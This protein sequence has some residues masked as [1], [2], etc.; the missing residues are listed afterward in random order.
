MSRRTMLGCIVAAVALMALATAGTA[1]V[2]HDQWYVLTLVKGEVT[3]SV[4]V[5]ELVYDQADTLALT[6]QEGYLY[7]YTV[8]NDDYKLSDLDLFG[9]KVAPPGVFWTTVKNPGDGTGWTYGVW[10]CGAHTIYGWKAASG[11]LKWGM[12]CGVFWMVSTYPPYQMLPAGACDVST[13]DCH[14]GEISAPTGPPPDEFETYTPGGWGARPRGNN[15]GSLL[16]DHYADIYPPSPG[17][18]VIGNAGGD[19]NA[20]FTSAQAITDW[21]PSGG[22][23][24]ALSQDHVNPTKQELKNSLADHVLALQLSV[25]FSNAG[26]TP[27]GLASYTLP[28]GLLAGKTVGEAL[29]MANRVL[30]AV[31]VAGDLSPADMLTVVAAINEMFVP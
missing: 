7:A 8:M 24:A 13:Q 15:A 26:Y 28:T 18:V 14:E 12:E 25:D 27:P 10:A 17:G 21:M 20:K 19:Y 31:P 5:R 6:G 29:A 4:E 30:G 9:F 1:G 3:T 22:T 2:L 11:G 16:H 23:A